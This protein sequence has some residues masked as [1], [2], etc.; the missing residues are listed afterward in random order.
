M[1]CHSEVQISDT[2]MADH[3]MLL[4]H[5][6]EWKCLPIEWNVSML[7]ERVSMLSE[8][9]TMLSERVTVLSER[10]TRVNDTQWIELLF[11]VIWSQMV[12]YLRQR[13]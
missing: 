12:L 2:N 8:R 4:S 3:V 10:V 13:N 5:R 11:R 1:Y 9:V 6:S 7:S